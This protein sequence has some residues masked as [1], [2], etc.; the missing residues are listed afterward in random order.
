MKS[1]K[2]FCKWLSE[3][4]VE[5]PIV[6]G[7]LLAKSSTSSVPLISTIHTGH[8]CIRICLYDFIV[9]CL[10]DLEDDQGLQQAI[11][12]SYGQR[13]SLLVMYC[14]VQFCSL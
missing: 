9:V 3:A 6:H 7:F 10:Q 12:T 8:T 1:I 4:K 13:P 2:L 11:K 5:A 14:R